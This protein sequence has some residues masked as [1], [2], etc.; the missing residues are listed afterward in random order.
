MR[1]DTDDNPIFI[2]AGME[3]RKIAWNW[4]GSVLAIAGKKRDCYYLFLKFDGIFRLQI[5]SPIW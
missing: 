2:D 5:S 1:S 4:N 3:V